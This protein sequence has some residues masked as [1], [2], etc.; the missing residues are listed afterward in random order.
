ML[1]YDNV[2]D[3]YSVQ[4]MDGIVVRGR[5]LYISLSELHHKPDLLKASNIAYTVRQTEGKTVA[6][7]I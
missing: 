7:A 1:L 5:R 3:A 4:A 2:N 6:D